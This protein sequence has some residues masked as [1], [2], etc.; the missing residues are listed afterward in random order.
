MRSSWHVGSSPRAFRFDCPLAMRGRRVGSAS[1]A[2]SRPH[3]VPLH[4]P[5]VTGVSVTPDWRTIHGSVGS[6]SG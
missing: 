3:E 4:V 6:R 1:I 2:K 5:D